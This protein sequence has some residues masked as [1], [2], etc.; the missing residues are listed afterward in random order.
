M[1]LNLGQAE[2]RSVRVP[3]PAHDANQ[4]LHV[5]ATARPT[6]AVRVP[7]TVASQLN[8]I[9]VLPDVVPHAHVRQ[10]TV[11]YEFT[12]RLLDLIAGSTLLVITAPIIL[13]AAAW[14]R[15]ESPGSPFFFQT[16]LGKDGKPFRIFKLRGMYRDARERY[17]E[18]YD[19]SHNRSLD[20]H[21]HYSTDPRVTRAGQFLRR[22][23]IDELPNLWNVITGDMSLIGPRPEIPDIL[24][25]Y[26]SYREAYLSVKPG[27]SCRSKV[28]GRDMLTKRE[29][30]EF[31][32]QYIRN[33][34]VAEDLSILWKT[35]KLVVL[36][37]DV[38]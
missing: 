6:A 34:G 29:S 38:Y 18:L 20:F 2:K 11:A 10:N 7:K 37:R 4:P 13:A 27:V 25:M 3:P 32:L 19:Y 14:I 26:G 36:R 12:K 33:R 21:F 9:Q 28:T 16:R 23:S 5:A 35:F 31:D 1:S 22:T 30:I 15:L 8:V 24:A 17:P